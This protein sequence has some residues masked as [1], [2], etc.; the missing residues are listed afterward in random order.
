MIDVSPR[1]RA[2]LRRTGILVL[3][4]AIAISAVAAPPTLIGRDAPDFALKGLDGTNLRLSEYRGRVVLINFWARWAGD[5][6]VEMP[7]L[8]RIDT[9]YRRAGL[10]VLGVSIDADAARAAEFATAMHVS[11]P[12]LLDTLELT[13]R[14]YAI[15]RLPTTVLVDRSGVV[16]Y[17]S[18]GFKH[19]DER[20][21]VDQIHQLLRE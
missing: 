8:G 1:A 20:M 15:R 12:T 14:E 4:S 3:L 2:G 18:T 16:R 7:A 11:Y 21:L 9:T 10:V 19:G 6:R 5:T 17:V 13:G